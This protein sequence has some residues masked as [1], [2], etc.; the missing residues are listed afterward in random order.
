MDDIIDM[1]LDSPW[2]FFA[3]GFIGGACAVAAL[4]FVWAFQV[5]A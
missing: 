2:A 1:L 5:M 3:L 4:I